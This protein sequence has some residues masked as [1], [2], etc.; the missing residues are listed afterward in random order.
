[1]IQPATVMVTKSGEAYDGSAVVNM[2]DYGL[3]PPTLLWALLGP[4]G[5]DE[6]QVSSHGPVSWGDAS[7]S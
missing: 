1:M 2:R 6:G 3:K 5:T 4:K 7:Y